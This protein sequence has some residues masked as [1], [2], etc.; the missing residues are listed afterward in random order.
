LFQSIND[1]RKKLLKV[2]G[3]WIAK[4]KSEK[5]KK[6]NPLSSYTTMPHY[7]PTEQ[8]DIVRKLKSKRKVKLG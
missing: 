6:R 2:L 8:V 3:I 7:F 1:L 5:A 4:K